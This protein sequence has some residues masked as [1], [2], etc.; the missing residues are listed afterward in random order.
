M[1]EQLPSRNHPEPFTGRARVNYRLAAMLICALAM[2]IV[3]GIAGWNGQG[4]IANWP[5][6]GIGGL[7][8]GVLTGFSVPVLAF[9]LPY[10]L[11]WTNFNRTKANLVVV[12]VWA[13]I[14][15]PMWL[16]S[17]WSGVVLR[18]IRFIPILVVLSLIGWWIHS[19]IK[20][21]PPATGEPTLPT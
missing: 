1:V 16:A 14:L 15:F 19:A 12:A 11:G 13:L 18:L 9:G 2:A 21:C 10:W 17:G 8:V 3:L 4:G 6:P 20:R 7:A 5:G